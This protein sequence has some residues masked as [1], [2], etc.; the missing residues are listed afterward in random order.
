[1]RSPETLGVEEQLGV[2]D[3]Y[4]NET[5]VDELEAFPRLDGEL[6]PLIAANAEVIVSC[7][8]MGGAEVSLS[9]AM[10][11]YPVPMTEEIAGQIIA[12]VYELL[13]NRV[14]EETEEEEALQTEDDDQADN[15][16][17]E[18]KEKQK[19]LNKV[20]AWG[21]PKEEIEEIEHQEL[22]ANE[23]EETSEPEESAVVEPKAEA[24]PSVIKDG[25]G[26][27]APDSAKTKATH[28]SSNGAEDSISFARPA[29][30]AIAT[31][32]SGTPENS[33]QEFIAE[34]PAANNPLDEIKP[35]VE[36]QAEPQQP[37]PALKIPETGAKP[38]AGIDPELHR[39]QP[40]QNQ[41]AEAFTLPIATEVVMEPGYA[42]PL[43]LDPE[44]IVTSGDTTEP[45]GEEAD[46]V[47]EES[48]LAT[49]GDRIEIMGP[50]SS[51]AT[52]VL[53]EDV[54]EIDEEG[55]ILQVDN[56]P[57]FAEQT[58]TATAGPERTS[59]NNLPVAKIEDSLVQL[60]GLIEEGEPEIIEEISETLDKIIEISTMFEVGGDDDIVAEAQAE[61]EELFTELFDS[62]DMDYTPELVGSLAGLTV[63]RN[64]SDEIEKLK[65]GE[66]AV[67]E[68]PHDTGTHEIIKQLLIGLSTIK[69]TV[70]HACAIG[71][72]ALYLSSNIANGLSV[73]GPG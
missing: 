40:V 62:M 41:D 73:Q 26:Q 59:E 54:L 4:A 72:S 58:E 51:A 5:I 71:R 70:T 23:A 24:V 6:M 18:N 49:P 28:N 47:G 32:S 30:S 36:P 29:S 66:D 19:D 25:P 33:A 69:K 12:D 48:T 61:I 21:Q 31:A 60:A 45:T 50:S 11:N 56:K 15:K 22:S 16:E 20:D 14:T 8:W 34:Q 65:D 46:T 43:P 1:L 63:R 57:S 42:E 52:D 13:A 2:P 37:M 44:S 67:D 9:T 38:I 17:A 3:A 64:L 55:L 27:P 53:L 35:S 7:R 10:I 39:P 68:S